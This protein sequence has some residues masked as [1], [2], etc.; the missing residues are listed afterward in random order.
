MAQCTEE[1]KDRAPLHPHIV[2]GDDFPDMESF[3]AK[4]PLSS[5][6]EGDSGTL[7]TCY[8]HI[9]NRDLRD[10]GMKEYCERHLLES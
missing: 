7:D 9:S 10:A 5:L 8:E 1:Q 3:Y 6:R 4:D 2:E